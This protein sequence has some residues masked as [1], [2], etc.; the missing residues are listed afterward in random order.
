MSTRD[1]CTVSSGSIPQVLP[2]VT[3]YYTW[4]VCTTSFLV[5][6]SLLEAFGA[7]LPTPW[8]GFLVVAVVMS[9]AFIPFTYGRTY[10]R[11]ADCLRSRGTSTGS[12]N[13]EDRGTCR[14]RLRGTW[15]D[16][17]LEDDTLGGETSPLLGA[18]GGVNM[19][20]EDLD[21]CNLTWRQCLQVL[22][23]TSMRDSYYKYLV[24]TA[25][26]WEYTLVG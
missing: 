7:S 20:D 21:N 17:D 23:D 25:R 24:H 16:N 14:G 8:T 26:C 4:F 10:I 3:P 5:T 13:S 18:V 15:Q 6:A 2:S 19:V 11:D 22:S 1:C 12:D 9:V